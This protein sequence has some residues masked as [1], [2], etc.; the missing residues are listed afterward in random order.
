[1]ERTYSQLTK[2][3]FK[4][5]RFLND[6]YYPISNPTV[7]RRDFSYREDKII[8]QKL[9]LDLMQTVLLAK[10]HIK[11]SHPKIVKIEIGIDNPD[12][13]KKQKFITIEDE[14]EVVGGRLRVVTLGSLPCRYLRITF[15]K[16]CPIMDYKTIE[17]FG[18]VKKDMQKNFTE[19][20]Q[21]LLYY[22]PYDFIYD[23]KNEASS[24]Q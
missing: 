3:P 17:L 20:L 14:I 2:I 1:M 23:G 8:Q 19:D 15:L 18:V 9:L 4:P 24:Y 21:D 10:L 7:I 16:G 13:P 6:H 22:N 12:N 5:V 11:P